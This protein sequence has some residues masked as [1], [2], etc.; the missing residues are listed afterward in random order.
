MTK[1]QEIYRAAFVIGS[2][3]VMLGLV[4]IPSLLMVIFG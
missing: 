4:M 1:N 3:V 2:A